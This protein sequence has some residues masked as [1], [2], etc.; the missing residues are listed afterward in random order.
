VNKPIPTDN[1]IW[2]WLLRHR[3]SIRAIRNKDLP[4]DADLPLP[5]MAVPVIR[6]NAFLGAILLSGRARGGAFSREE[7]MLLNFV[8][9]VASVAFGS[10]KDREAVEKSYVSTMASLM[11]TV[12]AKDSY[13]RG[14][15]ER[16]VVFAT[17]LAKAVGV[18]GRQL[19][20][21]EWAAALHDIGKIAL[22][23]AILTKAGPLTADEYGVMKEHTTRG[24]RILQHLKY[25]DTARM[26]IRAHHER[27]DG[28]GYPDGLAGEEIPLGARIMAIADSYDA[29]TSARPYRHAMDPQDALAEI[30]VNAGTQFD[31]KLVATFLTIMRSRVTQ[32]SPVGIPSG[33]TS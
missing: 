21:I 15:T 9:D 4:E 26:I 24:D 33:A 32:Q 31:P 23:D 12:E 20:E 8:A 27:Y 5:V 29:M 10:F 18:A 3:R 2:A 25:L 30:E 11:E 7:G 28:R 22:P 1:G 13:T 14:H 19:Q 17:E 6:D 16:V